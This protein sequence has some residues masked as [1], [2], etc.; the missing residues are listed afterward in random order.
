M[1]LGKRFILGVDKEVTPKMNLKMF[2]CS[3]CF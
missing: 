3:L 2:G 1:S